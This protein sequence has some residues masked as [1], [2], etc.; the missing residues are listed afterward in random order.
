MDTTDPTVRPGDDAG[1]LSVNLAASVEKADAHTKLKLMRDVM[2]G[3]VD[4]L[5]EARNE[6]LKRDFEARERYIADRVD[7]LERRLDVLEQ[8]VR[9]LK[10]SS[11]TYHGQAIS[12]IGDALSGLSEKLHGLRERVQFNEISNR[13]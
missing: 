11:T 1:A 8:H 9:A 5:V 4:Q 10:E 7:G 13:H 3:P 2:I 6:K 12:D